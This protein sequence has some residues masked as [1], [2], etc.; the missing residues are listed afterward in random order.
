MSSD[1]A[2]VLEVLVALRK[3]G[4]EAI[5]VGNGAAVLQGVPVTTQDLD[6]LVRDRSISSSITSSEGG[7]SPPS[8]AA[9]TGSLSTKRLPSSQI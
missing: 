3:V 1:E 2:F 8:R 6:L 5:I 7:A 4:L 9:L